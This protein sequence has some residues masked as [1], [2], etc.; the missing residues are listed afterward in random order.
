VLGLQHANQSLQSAEDQYQ[1][2][3]CK[4]VTPAVE[5]GHVDWVVMHVCKCSSNRVL[6]HMDWAISNIKASLPFI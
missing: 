3:R 4:H 6:S 2:L 1:V 5:T